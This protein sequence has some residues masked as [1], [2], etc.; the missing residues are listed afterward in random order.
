V[1]IP[2]HIDPCSGISSVKKSLAKSAKIVT[3]N[4]K[5]NF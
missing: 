4:A 1:D 2:E 5:K 3:K